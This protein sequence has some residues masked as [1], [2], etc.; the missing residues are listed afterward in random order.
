MKYCK[1][2]ECPADN[3]CENCPFKNECD[4][5]WV[6]KLWNKTP[7]LSPCLPGWIKPD[8]RA[9]KMVTITGKY[10]FCVFNN[11]KKKDTVTIN[12]IAVDEEARG[13]GLSKQLIYG[14]MELS[15]K[16]VFAKC[17][18]GSSA[19]S[20]WQHLG[21]EK[22]GEEQSKKTIVCSYILKNKNKKQ[23]KEDLW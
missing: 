10:D 9:N 13:Q 15:D 5:P 18:K 12:D 8:I 6:S 19:E 16:D 20:F 14:I 3:K 21:A 11:A 4:W 1:C 2:L 22:L 7:N 23:D 17:I